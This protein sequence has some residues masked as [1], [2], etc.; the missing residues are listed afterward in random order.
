MLINLLLE[1]YKMAKRVQMPVDNNLVIL[2]NKNYLNEKQLADFL[3][4]DDSTI[5]KYKNYEN[6]LPIDLAVKL[7]DKYEYSLD[8]IYHREKT[9]SKNFMIDI[10]ELITCDENNI[11]IALSSKHMEYINKMFEIE[12][13]DE[14]ESIKYHEKSKITNQHI[15]K[16]DDNI[17][18]KAV[19]PKS[20]FLKYFCN[21]PFGDDKNQ[22]KT[23]RKPT[24]N[25]IKEVVELLED[26]GEEETK[27][28]KIKL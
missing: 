17:I 16:E 28:I 10:R 7:A 3:C 21:T 23:R 18:C 2:E 27:K 9:N 24:E 19:I 12:N 13:M 22:N 4:V 25:E 1:E 11:Y 14:R 6:N 20:N 26:T 5:R 8:W 15:E